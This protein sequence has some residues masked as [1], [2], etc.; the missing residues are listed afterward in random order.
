[1]NRNK[2]EIIFGAK[3]AGVT[4]L[5]AFPDSRA[6]DSARAC[7][8]RLGLSLSQLLCGPSPRG[9]ENG[10]RKLT[11]KD[12]ESPS[13]KIQITACEEFTRRCL[14]REAA[15]RG[16]SAEEY[17]VDAAM[18]VLASDEEQAFLDPA[19]GEVVATSGEF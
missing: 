2:D 4:W 17:I 10:P 5:H 13:L 6:L 8:K 15:H 14:E 12:R 7:A 11:Q 3:R 1:M 16:C 19:T 18:C 9:L